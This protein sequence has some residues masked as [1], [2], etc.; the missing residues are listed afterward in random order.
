MRVKVAR[1]FFENSSDF[2]LFTRAVGSDCEGDEEGA[3]DEGR[4]P[5]EIHDVLVAS[6]PDDGTGRSDN[7]LL[8]VSD[9]KSSSTPMGGDMIPGDVQ[10]LSSSSDSASFLD[11]N[12]LE[13]S[14]NDAE[15][16]VSVT[17]SVGLEGLGM[18]SSS[19]SSTCNSAS[20]SSSR[21]RSSS[22]ERLTLSFL[23]SILAGAGAGSS[24]LTT[25]SST[26][27][28]SEA[29]ACCEDEERRGFLFS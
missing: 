18:S 5:S 20:F 4:V 19:S 13:S 15:S 9:W 7:F 14:Q 29:E 22:I 10:T 8:R 1:L 23:S 27:I 25:A 16:S 3:D 24:S 28:S 6:F 11:H 21:F 2:L 12:E 26:S 17:D